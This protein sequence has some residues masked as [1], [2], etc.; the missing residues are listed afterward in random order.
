MG[1]YPLK[2]HEPLNELLGHHLTVG[3]FS[4][5][6]SFGR[7]RNN[8]FEIEKRLWQ[9]R[10]R[11]AWLVGRLSTRPVSTA[12]IF[13]ARCYAS[14]VLATD[15]CPTVCLCLSQVGVLSKRLN[16]SSWF[17]GIWASFHPSYTVLKGNSDISKNNGTSVWNFVLKSGLRKFHHGIS[18]AETW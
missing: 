10:P 9:S 8:R 4:S 11:L 17:F 15:L 6:H 18:I 14:A 7:F 16:E 13:T 3:P 12:A 5:K 2:T 1:R